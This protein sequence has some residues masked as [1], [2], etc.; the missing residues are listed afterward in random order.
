MEHKEI[1]KGFG[2]TTW[3]S[4]SK[5]PESIK[6]IMTD[7]VTVEYVPKIVQPHPAFETAVGIIR[8]WNEGYPKHEK[9]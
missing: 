9:K 4:G 2:S 3:S 5:Y 6:V 1:P 7:D 8:K